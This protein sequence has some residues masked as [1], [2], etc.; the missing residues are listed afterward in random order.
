MGGYEDSSG[1]HGYVYDGSTYATL[2]V[3]GGS[4]TEAIGIDDGNIVG[5]Y[6][7]GSDICGFLFTPDTVAVPTPAALVLSGLGAGLVLCLRRWKTL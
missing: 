1:T 2:D 5:F 6:T 3:P 4:S 7:Q